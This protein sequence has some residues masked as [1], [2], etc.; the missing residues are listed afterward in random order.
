MMQNQGMLA[1]CL[2]IRCSVQNQDFCK[3]VVKKKGRENDLICNLFSRYNPQSL[4]THMQNLYYWIQ[5]IM[6]NLN[7]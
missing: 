1:G 3:K 4:P 7:M 6:H 2:Q 5:I